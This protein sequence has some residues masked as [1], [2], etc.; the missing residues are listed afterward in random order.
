MIEFSANKICRG[1]NISEKPHIPA[2]MREKVNNKILNY[3]S[4]I[5]LLWCTVITA[6]K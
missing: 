5:C 4:H 1:E 3:F 2:A 6:F